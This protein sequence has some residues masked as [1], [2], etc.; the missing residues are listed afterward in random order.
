MTQKE[1]PTTPKWKRET[2]QVIAKTLLDHIAS[3]LDGKWYRT[4]TLDY[5]GR[6]TY[7]YIV[8]H[9]IIEES[10]CPDSDVSGGD[11]SNA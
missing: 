5:K 6:R 10:D 2:N 3:L 1:S 9:D 8:E 7:R 4:E 11:S